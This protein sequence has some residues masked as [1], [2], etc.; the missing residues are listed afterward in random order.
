LDGRRQV[1]QIY[2]N[3]LQRTQPMRG[4]AA[5]QV[6]DTGNPGSFTIEFDKPGNEEV[7]CFATEQ[8]MITKLPPLLRGPALQPLMGVSSLDDMQ[9]AFSAVL[10]ENRFGVARAKWTVG[11]K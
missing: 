2:P 11:K 4:N 5:V 1:S 10:G 6:P 8:E 3:P 7:A 9:K